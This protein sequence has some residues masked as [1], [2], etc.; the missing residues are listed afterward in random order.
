MCLAFVST[1]ETGHDEKRDKQD[2]EHVEVYPA[3][4]MKAKGLNLVKW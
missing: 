1:F 2:L 4:E 3:D